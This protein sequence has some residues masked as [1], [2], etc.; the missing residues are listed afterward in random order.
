MSENERETKKTAALPKIS[1]CWR[2]NLTEVGNGQVS[3]SFHAGRASHKVGNYLNQ[4]YQLK[5][6][7]D[8]SA[9]L[10]IQKSGKS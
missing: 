4:D 8:E 7:Q 2:E 10:R 1:S 9:I 5:D 6:Q 3:G